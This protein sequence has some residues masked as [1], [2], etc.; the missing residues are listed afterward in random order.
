DVRSFLGL[1]RYLDQFLPHLADHTHVLTPLTTKTNEQDWPGWND[2]HQ[3]A[4]NA[5]KR[6]VVSRECLIT[7]DHD[8][9][10]ENKIFVTCD[11]SD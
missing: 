1:V 4:F 11:A 9:I 7:I 10:G 5:I 2:E 8:N 6:L 3:E